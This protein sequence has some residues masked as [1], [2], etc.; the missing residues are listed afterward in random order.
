MQTVIA[1]ANKYIQSKQDRNHSKLD[2]YPH[3]FESISIEI[4]DMKVF[5]PPT[6]QCGV[7]DSA[8]PCVRLLRTYRELCHAV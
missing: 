2:K 6:I 3:K 7:T 4:S 8:V 1:I 5:P